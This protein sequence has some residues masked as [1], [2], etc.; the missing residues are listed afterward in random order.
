MQEL[1]SKT[2]DPKAPLRG[3][4]FCE[5]CLYDSNSAGK[6]IFCVREARA[7]WDEV[8][9]RAAWNEEQI[10]AYATAKEAQERYAERRLLLAQEGFIYSDMDLF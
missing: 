2:D 3:Q 4:E 10:K 6:R 8:H 7:R 1:F 5:L 9:G